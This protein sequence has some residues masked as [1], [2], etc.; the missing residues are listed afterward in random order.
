MR[1]CFCCKKNMDVKFYDAYFF[2][3]DDWNICESCFHDISINAIQECNMHYPKLRRD[4]SYF[5]DEREYLETHIYDAVYKKFYKKIV[6]AKYKKNRIAIE[7]KLKN[8]ISKE[9]LKELRENGVCELTGATNDLTIEHF[10]PVSWGHGGS[11]YGNIFVVSRE[12]NSSKQ[13]KNPFKWIKNVHYD[14]D[15]SRWDSLV[16]RLAK[17]NGMS[18]KEF[19]QYVNW[20]EKNKRSIQDLEIDNT[21]SVD[22]WKNRSK[23]A[24]CQ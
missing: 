20:C 16:S 13:I 23:N 1:K 2:R 18:V 5:Y 24:N 6:S 3:D 9:E 7:K 8:T 17:L 12:V 14:I 19:R 10:I 15:S 21:F 4:S 11:Y 22:A